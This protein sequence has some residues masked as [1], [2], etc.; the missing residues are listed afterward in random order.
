MIKS[1][2]I[3]F[4]RFDNRGFYSKPYN[5]DYKYDRSNHFCH[6]L[7]FIDF[8]VTNLEETDLVVRKET[9]IRPDINDKK[10]SGCFSFLHT[11]DKSLFDNAMKFRRFHKKNVAY[12]LSNLNEIVWVRN[13]TH[14]GHMSRYISKYSEYW[15]EQNQTTESYFGYNSHPELYWVKMKLGLAI[16]RIKLGQKHLNWTPEWLSEVFLT[17]DQL[18]RLEPYSLKIFLTH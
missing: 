12:L 2:Y 9:I 5:S 1:K 17:N 4:I 10:W 14:T 11:Y 6:V 13:T 16:E 7:P 3:K 8:E 15:E 18:Q